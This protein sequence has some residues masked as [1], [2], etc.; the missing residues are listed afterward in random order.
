[1]AYV[2]K[3]EPC[4]K[5]NNPVFFAERLVIEDQL[6]HRTCFKCARCSSVLTLGNFYQTENDNEF[7][8]ETCPDEERSRAA[9]NTENRLSIAQRIAL[10]EKD[11]SVLRKSVS[12]EE[13]SKSLSR[14]L[15]TTSP[16]SQGLSKFLST[17]IA[18]QNQAESDED[19]KTVNS[20]DSDSD[21]DVK[22]PKEQDQ[23]PMINDIN[24]ATKS[25]AISDNVDTTKEE[26]T[27]HNNAQQAPA[28]ESQ[29]PETS[30]TIN[31]STFTAIIA[32]TDDINDLS[33]LQDD[34]E[35]EFERLAE[36]AVNSPITTPLVIAQ[37]P[38]PQIVKDEIKLDQIDVSETAAIIEKEEEKIEKEKETD[39]HEEVL[40]PVD[41][42]EEN[43]NEYPDDLNPFGDDEEEV[44]TSVIRPSLNPFG[45]CSEDDEANDSKEI[46]RSVN[47]GTLPKPPRPPPPKT[48]SKHVSTN[49]FGSDD[50]EEQDVPARPP[51]IRTP[52]PTPRRPL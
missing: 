4:V 14:Q 8:C 28:V 31:D 37:K 39:I 29:Q 49:P 51:S 3:R 17:Q 45:S 11:S 20:S 35:L 7:C 47:T 16:S 44:K 22:A 1:M 23:S 9:K 21:D 19:E 15:P 24:A 33:N 43:K 41:L 40:N 36:E 27:L 2:P 10:F 12:D 38:T 13:K 25:D 6:Y 46:N 52:V 50:E 18:S 30:T 26:I 42:T 5:C 48:A 32:T 34:I